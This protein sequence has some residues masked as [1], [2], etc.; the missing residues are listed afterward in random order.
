MSGCLNPVAADVC[1]SRHRRKCI[2]RDTTMRGPARGSGRR[3]CRRQRVRLSSRPAQHRASCRPATSCRVRWPR[4][5]GTYAPALAGEDGS[6]L[7][8]SSCNAFRAPAT[9]RRRPDPSV[10]DR[11]QYLVA[12]EPADLVVLGATGSPLAVTSTNSMMNSDSESRRSMSVVPISITAIESSSASSRR[13]ASSRLP[14]SSILPPGNSQS[15]P[16]RLCPG[17]RQT[18]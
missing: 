18:R 2:G 12:A 15:P 5:S 16:C 7:S 6:R 1:I 3:A 14:P 13:A 4:R 8:G 10:R 9:I 17:R 11:A